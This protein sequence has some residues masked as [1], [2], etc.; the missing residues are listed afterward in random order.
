MVPIVI[1]LMLAFVIGDVCR[2]VGTGNQIARFFPR[3]VGVSE[4][5]LRIVGRRGNTAAGLPVRRSANRA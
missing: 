3:N 5:E 2:A 1:L 4:K